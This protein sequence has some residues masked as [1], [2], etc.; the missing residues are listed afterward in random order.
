MI[1]DYRCIFAW[2]NHVDALSPA[3]VS[4]SGGSWVTTLPLS[5]MK[6]PLLSRV[7][8]SLD[9]TAAATTF[10]VD[11]GVSGRFIRVFAIPRHTMGIAATL[12]IRGSSSASDF[13]SA[14]E[15]KGASGASAGVYAVPT[16]FGSSGT[17]EFS[18]SL[19]VSPQTGAV[20]SKQAVGLWDQTAGTWRHLVLLTFDAAGTPT[21]SSA[22]GAGARSVSAE[23]DGYWRISCSANSCVAGNT[24]RL[25]WF[26]NDYAAASGD[27]YGIGCR[28]FVKDAA[29]TGSAYTSGSPNILPTA[30]DMTSVSWTLQNGAT[31]NRVGLQQVGGPQSYDSGWVDVW[32]LMWDVGVLPWGHPNAWTRRITEEQ[33]SFYRA[34][35]VHIAD[36]GYQGRYWRWEILDTTNAAGYIDLAR[37][38]M[39]PG[40]QPS[41]NFQFGASFG[42]QDT[43]AYDESMGGVRFYDRRPQRRVQTM[44]FDLPDDEILGV[45]QEMQR[46]LG[47]SGQ[48]YWAHAS[49]DTF[50]LVRRAMLATIKEP[51]PMEYAY[52]GRGKLPLTLEEVL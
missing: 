15:M 2:P 42:I 33:I 41:T 12:R 50:H 20:T 24:H 46:E 14:V 30:D 22:S 38:V 3:T 18:I 40:Y 11:L 45:M 25:V 37:L 32:P 44:V 28:P 9:V 4:F 8:R 26:G 31:W 27:Q 19:K 48:V 17:K 29:T 36:T 34:G 35:F 49:N 47:L 13:G 39:S 43:T 21:S 7:A 51:S 6:D 1:S 16:V 52:Y 23:S 10:D 5:N